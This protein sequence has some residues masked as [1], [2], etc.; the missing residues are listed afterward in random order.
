MTP[1][2]YTTTNPS[3]MY[4]YGIKLKWVEDCSSYLEITRSSWRSEKVGVVPMGGNTQ[5]GTKNPSL[6]WLQKRKFWL[7]TEFWITHL[8][9]IFTLKLWLF[10]GTSA[11]VGSWYSLW[12]AWQLVTCFKSFDFQASSLSV[13]LGPNRFLRLVYNHLG[14]L[15]P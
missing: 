11:I 2:L 3:K 15:C 14:F 6:Q 5:S 10:S 9:F 13:P 4:I 1:K 7:I 12:L 8:L